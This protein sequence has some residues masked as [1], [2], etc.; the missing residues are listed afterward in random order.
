MELTPDSLNPHHSDA[1]PTHLDLGSTAKTASFLFVSE[2]HD[3]RSA[4]SQSP[5]RKCNFSQSNGPG[6]PNRARSGLWIGQ[7]ASYTCAMI[8]SCSH[9]GGVSERE[10]SYRRGSHER[11]CMV[12]NNKATWLRY[13]GI[14]AHS[15]V[16]VEPPEILI[17]Q[18]GSKTVTG[19]LYKKQYKLAMF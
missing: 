2:V 6:T 7:E 15:N 3:T 12:K 1:A 19:Y 4:A 11:T 18:Y 17:C 14:M 9:V 5:T 13:K 8:G 16:V 10:E